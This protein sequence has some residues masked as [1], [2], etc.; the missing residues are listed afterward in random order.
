MV[1]AHPK[2]QAG[3]ADAACADFRLS[4]VVGNT[5]HFW[6]VVPA[7]CTNRQGLGQTAPLGLGHLLV[8]KV[9]KGDDSAAPY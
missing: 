3:R 5:A 2:V 1:S 9:G 8:L 7:L 4:Y 6:A